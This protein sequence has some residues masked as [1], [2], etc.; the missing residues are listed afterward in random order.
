M[1]WWEWV[2]FLI[3]VYTEA[4]LEASWQKLVCSSC[5]GRA[6]RF[7]RVMAAL[8][9]GGR[10][11]DY[12]FLTECLKPVFRIPPINQRRWITESTLYLFFWSENC[13]HYC[14]WQCSNWAGRR[15]LAVHSLLA[16]ISTTLGKWPQYFKTQ[17]LDCQR[18]IR[19]R[20]ESLIQ[21][22]QHSRKRHNHDVSIS[23]GDKHITHVT[24]RSHVFIWT[25]I[26]CFLH[27][28]LINNNLFDVY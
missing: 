6:F 16:R 9:G 24:C 15:F 11:S 13:Q 12:R 21:Y 25:L 7:D 23:C 28:E 17:C 3:L 2:E 14:H 22:F 5:S 18:E 8:S 19:V 10:N 26:Q 27:G 1:G 20:I 4:S